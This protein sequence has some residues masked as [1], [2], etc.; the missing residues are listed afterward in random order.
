MSLWFVSHLFSVATAAACSDLSIYTKH[1]DEIKNVL[2][3]LRLM[4][5]CVTALN[6]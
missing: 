3:Y 6:L 1:P 4:V 5:K 2:P